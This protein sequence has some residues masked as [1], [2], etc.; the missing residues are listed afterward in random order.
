MDPRASS[1]T[2]RAWNLGGTR[3]LVRRLN[4]FTRLVRLLSSIRLAMALILGIALVV[5]VGTVVDQ[6]PVVM[7]ADPAAYTRWLDVE[8]G[9]YGSW[10]GLLQRLDLFNV[11]H[12]TVFRGLIA[13]LAVSIVVCTM[14]RWRSVWVLTFHTRVRMTETFLTHA[15]FHETMDVAMP[16]AQAAEQVRKSL[17]GARYRVRTEAAGTSVAVFAEKN[18]FSR[19]GT[20]F[21]HLGLVL[22][23]V[24]AIA[25]G[26]WGFKDPQFVVAEGSTKDVGQ[27]TN[28]AVRLDRFTADYYPDG[29]PKAYLSD[30]T[31]L[32]DGKVVKQGT[33]GVNS[34]LHYGGIAFHESYYGPAAVLKVQ[35]STGQVIFEG[36]VP[37]TLKTADGLRPEGSFELPDQN[38]LVYVIGPTSGQAD[39]L[40][41]PGEVRLD[42]Y[43]DYIRVAR[44]GNIVQGQPTP[45]GDMTF[46]FEREGAFTGMQLVKDPGVNLIWVAGGLMIVGM[47]MLFYLPPRRLWALCKAKDD[48]SSEVLIGMQG[49]RDI[50]L[51]GEFGKLRGRIAKALGREA[52]EQGY[53]EGDEDV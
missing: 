28:L 17:S 37:L 50:S 26:V 2:L 9:K 47:V 10:M 12:S 53:E 43:Q 23:L 41:P 4:P 36:G 48:G 42:F 27:G 8:R 19:F 22:I 40:V 33:V 45:I 31:V 51:A 32:K 38:L 5:L 49:Q 14:R 6:V 16:A 11:F 46:T 18:R 34:P 29:R 21:T 52:G 20:F 15:K 24:G 13:L 1:G 25:G 30:M 44:P 7:R 35:D 39:S 3:S